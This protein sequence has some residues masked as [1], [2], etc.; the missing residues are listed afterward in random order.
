[1]TTPITC[2][3]KDSRHL[4]QVSV[5]IDHV[6]CG[7]DLRAGVVGNREQYVLECLLS[8]MW[9]THLVGSNPVVRHL[10]TELPWS[11]LKFYWNGFYLYRTAQIDTKT[12]GCGVQPTRKTIS[13]RQKFICFEI[14]WLEFTVFTKA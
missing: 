8:I 5:E 9:R 11:H 2:R 4:S 3:R 10:T 13:I 1:M 12:A 6:V 7:K 14:M